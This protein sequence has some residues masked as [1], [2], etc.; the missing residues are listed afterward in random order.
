MFT[1]EGSSEPGVGTLVY[2]TLVFCPLC[3]LSIYVK[4]QL[5]FLFCVSRRKENNTE[6]E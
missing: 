1:V 3:P 5:R 4:E 2:G 6:L